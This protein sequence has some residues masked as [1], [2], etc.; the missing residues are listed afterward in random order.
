MSTL[1]NNEAHA[2]IAGWHAD[3]QHSSINRSTDLAGL[4]LINFLL[5]LR[6]A[7][8]KLL[9]ETM[10]GARQAYEATVEADGSTVALPGTAAA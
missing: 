10:E 2:V 9:N 4:D 3:A 6:M 7:A 1:I 8:L 5:D